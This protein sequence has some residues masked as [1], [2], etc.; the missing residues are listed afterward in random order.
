MG[1]TQSHHNRGR[2]QR[3]IER[4]PPPP[5]SEAMDQ[6]TSL[7]QRDVIQ[8]PSSSLPPFGSSRPAGPLTQARFMELGLPD[9]AL[10]ERRHAPESCHAYDKALVKLQERISAIETSTGFISRQGEAVDNQRRIDEAYKKGQ[11]VQERVFRDQMKSLKD[12]KR[13]LEDESRNLEEQRKG[14]EHQKES[15]QDR[16]RNLEIQKKSLNRYKHTIISQ[17][18]TIMSQE[19]Q[20]SDKDRTIQRLEDELRNMSDRAGARPGKEKEQ[21]VSVSG[22]CCCTQY[23]GSLCRRHGFTYGS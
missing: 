5:Y 8:T 17:H 3:Q 12:R 20:I 19:N 10:S 18:T 4:N 15:L 21:A 13:S 2:Q 16:E 11:E 7:P 14:L 22:P 1:I 9:R 6:S 23:N